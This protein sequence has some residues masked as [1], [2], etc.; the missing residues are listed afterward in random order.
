MVF[1][2]AEDQTVADKTTAGRKQKHT[3]RKNHTVTGRGNI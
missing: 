2:G 3:E 1:A